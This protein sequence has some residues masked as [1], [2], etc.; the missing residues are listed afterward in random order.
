MD[1]NWPSRINFDRSLPPSV[2]V[3][4]SSFVVRSTNDKRR[5]TNDDVP[6]PL[7]LL[8]P[9]S[10]TVSCKMTSTLQPRQQLKPAVYI[11]LPRRRVGRMGDASDESVEGLV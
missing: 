10:C 6:R 4:R 7:S 8:P 1:L 5:T 3:R 11:P 9:P 2:I